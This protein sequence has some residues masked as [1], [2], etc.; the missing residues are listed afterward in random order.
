M[1]RFPLTPAEPE[2]REGTPFASSY[3]DVYHSVHGGIEQARQVFIAGTSLTDR[4]RG[5]D[6]FTVLETGFGLGLNFLA[7]W[8]VWRSAPRRPRRLHF[9]SVE[10]HPLRV[11]DLARM[12]AP[13]RELA[14]LSGELVAAWPLLLPGCQ[15][16]H[17]EEGGLTLT[18]LFGEVQELDQL[19]LQADALYLD[20]FSPARNPAMWSPEVMHILARKAAP[21]ARVATWSVAAEVRRN[22]EAAGFR[23]EKRPGFGAK[24]EM[25]VGVWGGAGPA[26]GRPPASVAIIGAGLA[27]TSLAQRLAE[28]SLHV[29]LFDARPAPAQQA[30]GNPIGV[31][32]P[33]FSREDN[34]ASRFSRAAFCYGMHHWD[35]LAAAGHNPRWI[36]C[37]VVQIARDH[38]EAHKWNEILADYPAEYIQTLEPEEIERLTGNRLGGYRVSLGGWI[39]PPSL[40]A[41]Q[42]ASQATRIDTRFPTAITALEPCPS[43]WRLTLQNRPETPEYQ[44]VILANADQATGFAPGLQLQA[45][46]G[47]LSYLPAGCLPPIQQVIA[48]EGYVTPAVDGIHVLGASYDLNDISTEPHALAHAGN[49]QRLAGLLPGWEK[50][51]SADR[52]QGRVAFRATTPDRLPIVGA[53]EPGLYACTGLGSRGIVWSALGAELLASMI[54]GEPLPLEQDL[55]ASVSPQRFRQ[56]P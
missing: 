21:G 33:L 27:G 44:T 50:N 22:L 15:R 5:R 25:L 40:C 11:A 48:R 6:G 20:G 12:L 46:R 2:L 14:M 38:A 18:L 51:F 31:F 49:L 1:A 17:F 28:R 9:V 24:R 43:G 56:R 35:R 45:V 52:L 53:L 34:H 7:T 23:V 32:R 55:V 4:W 39:S 37:G 54:F 10:K 16:L 19:V 36:S 13:Y 8:Q 30:S 41:A 26:P 3:G 29:S 42:I 47:Q